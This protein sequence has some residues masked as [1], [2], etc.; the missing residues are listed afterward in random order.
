M[1]QEFTG[2]KG[3]REWFVE[4]GFSIT[5]NHRNRC[6]WLAYKRSGIPARACECNK[7]KGMQIVA[8]PYESTWPDTQLTRYY[9]GCEV[10]ICGEAEGLWWKL[11]CYGASV[12]EVK[13]RLPEI[14]KMAIAAW[15]A[16]SPITIGSDE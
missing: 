1:T 15:N 4:Q 3:L 6:N 8:H 5:K 12:D 16:L 7:K 13:N 2:N 10:E 14:E 9:V 11:L